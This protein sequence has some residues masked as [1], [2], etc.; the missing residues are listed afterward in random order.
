M[1]Y[2]LLPEISFNIDETNLK[3]S[4]IN[5]FDNEENEIFISQSFCKYLKKLKELINENVSSWDIIKKYTNPY[6]FIHSNIPL[7]NHSISKY[8]PIS[9]AFFKLIEI[10]KH[11]ELLPNKDSIKTFHL[12]EGPGG[13]IEATNFLRKNKSDTYYGITLINESDNSVPNW[14]KSS[15]Y[16]RKNPNII[17]ETG[18]SKD[19]NILNDKNYRY[20]CNSYNNSMDIVTGDAGFDFSG[21]FNRQEN[22]IFPLLYTQI[23]YAI[24][25]QK[26]NGNF[27][28]KI[29]DIFLK[30]T[31][32][33]IYL[34]SC[35]YKKV[36]ITKPNTS[37][38]ANSEKYIVC[39]YFKYKSTK[40]LF[41]RFSNI[42]TI[43]NKI[44]FDQYE[45][46]SV[47][48]INIQSYYLTKISEI[49]GIFINQQVE[50]IL[51]TIKLISYGDKK[52]DKL[53]LMKSQNILKCIQ[54][55]EQFNI[56]YHKNV[57]PS[58][59]FMNKR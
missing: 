10:Y 44:D 35:F 39:K 34:L 58:N 22:N 31:C 45:L 16:L 47:L 33:I 51:N 4:F 9:R 32:Q 5:K 56:K 57:T 59:V 17:I 24:T 52:R 12:A 50:N 41:N 2:Y 48:N 8:K 14:K 49:N 46:T 42:I 25:L 40:H 30:N 15:N 18:P 53:E 36:Y 21:D 20:I 55:C 43:I 29:F 38:Y 19:G 27:V 37:R 1:L 11:F 26:Y 7:V 54:W 28:L 3:I 13:F 23:M 6:E